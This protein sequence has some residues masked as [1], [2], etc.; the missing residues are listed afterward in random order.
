MNFKELLSA[1]N[2]TDFY[3]GTARD[4]ANHPL[5]KL[6]PAKKQIGLTMSH[7][8]GADNKPAMLRASNFDAMPPIRARGGFDIE[9]QRLPFFREEMPLNEQLRQDLLTYSAA[10]N[11]YIKAAIAEI[12]DDRANLIDGATATRIR[13]IGQLLS[14]GSISFSNQGVTVAADYGFDSTTQATD[15]TSTLQWRNPSTAK[16]ISDL[17]DAKADGKLGTCVA[18]MTQATWLQL[19]AAAETKA[20][21][22]SGT[23]TIVREVDVKNYL[24]TFGI[25]I[26]IVDNVI[27][28]NTY[29][30]L[31]TG[32]EGTYFPD[33]VVAMFPAQQLGDMRFGTTPEEADLRAGISTVEAIQVVDTGV[34][35][36]SHVKAGPPVEI[37]TVVSMVALPNFPLA[38]K[39]QVLNVN[40]GA[41][42]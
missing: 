11:E 26:L 4:V 23:V 18:A 41:G 30:D 20:A 25:N 17:L 21:V 22:Y 12:Y 34:A 13:M 16:P 28:Q 33:S 42:T 38:K 24:G 19:I 37:S 1:Q 6:F 15:I 2:I 31:D 29:L 32:T 10:G 14:T 39:L 8:V 7:I 5:L 3:K 40:A 27:E 9:T 35:V 36:V